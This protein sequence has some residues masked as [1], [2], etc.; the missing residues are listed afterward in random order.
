MDE[1]ERIRRRIEVVVEEARVLLARGEN[2]VADWEGTDDELLAEIRR[3]LTAELLS[4][5]E[6]NRN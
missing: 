3:R 6:P 2:V 1:V 4:D 5:R